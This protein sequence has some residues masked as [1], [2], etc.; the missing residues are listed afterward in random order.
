[1]SADFGQVTLTR[2]EATTPITAYG[3]VISAAGD[4]QLAGNLG[5]CTGD[6]QTVPHAIGWAGAA[7]L[8][9]TR[10][11]HLRTRPSEPATSVK[12]PMDSLVSLSRIVNVIVVDATVPE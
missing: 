7:R 3:M 9:P 10:H 8:Y 11:R 12:G 5:P 4:Y 6:D 2:T 1:V